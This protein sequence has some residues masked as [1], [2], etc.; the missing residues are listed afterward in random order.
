M[1]ALYPQ[2]T[3]F[4]RAL[5]H[6]PPQRVSSP[7]GRDRTGRN[8]WAGQWVMGS[9]S[10]SLPSDFLSPAHTAPQLPSS[11]A[12]SSQSAPLPP[13]ESQQAL[14][15]MGPTRP[16]ISL[17][18]HISM[19]SPE[20]GGSMRGPFLCPRLCSLMLVAHHLMVGED[21]SPLFFQDPCPL[22]FP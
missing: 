11:P 12:S 19:S 5:I 21:C 4:Y 6:T 17:H 3:C 8:N 18:L 10:T 1:L 7:H 20:M 22:G 2:T 13:S 16:L 14:S 15:G 9:P